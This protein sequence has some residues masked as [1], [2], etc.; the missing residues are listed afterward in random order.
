MLILALNFAATAGI[1]VLQAINAK[2]DKNHV[3][4]PKSSSELR[5]WS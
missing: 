4:Y 1:D 2:I 5:R 3:K